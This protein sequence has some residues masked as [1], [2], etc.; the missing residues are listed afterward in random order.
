VFEKIGLPLS[1]LDKMHPEQLNDLRRRMIAIRNE[2]L[3]EALKEKDKE[4]RHGAYDCMDK[5]IIR[6]NKILMSK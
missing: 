4:Y 6:L 1:D 2:T 3:V 5:M